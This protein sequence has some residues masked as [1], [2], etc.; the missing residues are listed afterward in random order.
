MSALPAKYRRNQPLPAAQ[1]PPARPLHLPCGALLLDPPPKRDSVPLLTSSDTPL[2]GAPRFPGPS[3][4]CSML[5][6]VFVTLS[7]LLISQ[8]PSPACLPTCCPLPSA[9]AHV[10]PEGL[11]TSPQLHLQDLRQCLAPRSTQEMLG[12][13]MD[14]G[15]T[16][17]W[18]GRWMC[19]LTP[20]YISGPQE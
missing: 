11:H 10:F 6:K 17:G 8:L 20:E 4:P 3:L 15:R 5:P 19:L 7:H 13:W 14:G 1:R 18:V 9:C 16:G 2:P 12:G